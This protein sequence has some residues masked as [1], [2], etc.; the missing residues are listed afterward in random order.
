VGAVETFRAWFDKEPYAKATPS[1]AV[2]FP[3]NHEVS[4]HP[5]EGYEIAVHNALHR[6]QSKHGVLIDRARIVEA[7]LDVADDE[8]NVGFVGGIEKLPELERWV[9]EAISAVREAA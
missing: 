3:A 4:E 1:I 7:V 6:S 9:R 2:P 5:V 8:K